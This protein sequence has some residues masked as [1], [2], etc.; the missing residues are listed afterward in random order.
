MKTNVLVTLA[1]VLGLGY[2]A[3]RKPKMQAQNSNVL[4]DK[5]NSVAT[6]QAENEEPLMY[7]GKSAGLDTCTCKN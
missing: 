3:T 1:G 7:T 4:G 2:L 6:F 5:V